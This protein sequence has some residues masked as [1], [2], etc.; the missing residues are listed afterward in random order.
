MLKELDL[1]SSELQKLKGIGIGVTSN[2]QP[3]LVLTYEEKTTGEKAFPWMFWSLAAALFVIM[4]L[5]W[6]VM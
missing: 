2:D 3:F 1:D 6:Q 5:L 4:L